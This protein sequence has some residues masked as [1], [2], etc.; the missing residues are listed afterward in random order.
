[1]HIGLAFDLKPAEPPPAGLPDDLHEEFDSPAT[2]TAV[3]DVLRS[4]GHTVT[5]LGNGRP[6]LEALLSQ[7]PDLLFNFAEGSGVSRSREARV[8]AVCELLGVPYT[9]SDPL[10]LAVALDKDMT[11]RLAAS[12]GVRVPP[13]ITLAPPPEPDDYDGDFA[14]FPPILEE[15][16]LALPVIVKPT[17]EGSSKGIRYHSVVRSAARLGPAVVELWRTYRQP[18]L[19]EEFI[20]GDEVTVGIVGNDPPEPLGVMRMRPKRVP[21]ADFVYSLE[22]KRDWE[23]NVEYEAPARLPADVLRAVERD[24]LAVFTGLGCRDVA[25]A[26]FRIRDGVPFFLEINPLPGLSP[27][28]GDIVFLAYRLGMTYPQLVGRILD[29]AVRRYGLGGRSRPTGRR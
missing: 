29:A 22:V 4:L 11:R 6:L 10:A 27:E 8:P 26:D 7:P 14:E 17:C 20:A 9:G 24:A 25:R 13:G 5:E 23:A 16:G 3:A 2:V 12:L 21:V 1:M 19:V 18:V 15:A 28:S